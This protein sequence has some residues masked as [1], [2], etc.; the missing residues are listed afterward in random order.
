M[1]AREDKRLYNAYLLKEDLRDVFKSLDSTAAAEKLGKWLN[2]ACRSWTKEIK[3][4]SKKVRRHREAIVR[5]VELGV[6]NARVEAV[7]NKIKLTGRMATASAASTTSSR[8]SC[9]AAR[10]CR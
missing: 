1:I 7:N 8:S 4:L 9:C 10:T 5:A 6:S 3:E 2:R